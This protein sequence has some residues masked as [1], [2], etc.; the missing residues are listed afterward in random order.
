MQSKKHLEKIQDTVKLPSKGSQ[1]SGTRSKEETRSV[2]SELII[3]VDDDSE[4]EKSAAS[5][6]KTRE[7][8]GKIIIN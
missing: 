6:P 7:G 1:G 3:I 5:K 2:D 8:K 4:Q